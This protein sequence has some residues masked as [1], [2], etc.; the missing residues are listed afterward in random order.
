MPE[1][2]VLIKYK[3]NEDVRD[4]LIS[5]LKTKPFTEVE[6]AINFLKDSTE[7]DGQSF[8]SII[9]YLS[10]MPWIEVDSIMKVISSTTEKISLQEDEV[11]PVDESS[12]TNS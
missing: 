6:D 1:N 11:Q 3:L 5:Y 7:I 8:R 4:I 10:H 9:S 2:E 12:T